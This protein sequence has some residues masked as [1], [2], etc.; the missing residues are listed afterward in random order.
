M[1]IKDVDVELSKD[2]HL[3]ADSATYFKSKATADVLRKERVHITFSPPHTQNKNAFAERSIGVITNMAKALLF[4]A[5]LPTSLWPEAWAHAILIR[6]Y[7]PRNANEESKSPYEMRNGKAPPDVASTYALFGQR[8]MVYIPRDQRSTKMDEKSRK[9]IIVGYD[10]ATKAAK[11]LTMSAR[12]Q[13][14]MRISDQYKLNPKLPKKMLDVEK[15]KVLPH[16]EDEF[17]YNEFNSKILPRD[18]NKELELDDE[19]VKTEDGVSVIIEQYVPV[20]S[21]GESVVW[22]ESE[23]TESAQSSAA[24]ASNPS[25]G[26]AHQINAIQEESEAQAKIFT[27]AVM[28][29]INMIN[30]VARQAYSLGTAIKMWP[31]HAE[32]L[33]RAAENEIQGLIEKS[34]IPVPETEINKDDEI[35]KLM[36]IYSLKYDAGLFDKAKCRCCYRGQDEIQGLHYVEK[37]TDMPRLSTI[38]IFL[39]LAPYKDEVCAK[40]DISQAFLRAELEP[41]PANERRFVQFPPD[42]SP[43]NKQGNI[44]TYRAKTGIYGMHS[45]GRQWQEM[46]FAWLKRIGMIQNETDPALFQTYNLRIVVWTD[47]I[48]IRGAPSSVTWIKEQLQREFGDVRWKALDYVLGMDIER[49]MN[50]WLGIH[51]KSYIDKMID[52]EDLGQAKPKAVPIPPSTRITKEQRA[53]SVDLPLRTKYQSVLGQL[54]YLATWTRPDLAYPTSSL[55][56]VASSPKQYHL[57]IARRVMTYCKRDPALGL[58]WKPPENP[59]MKNQI[60]IYTDA[61]WAQEEGYKSQSGFVAMMNGAPIHWQS[62]KQEFPALSSTESEIMAGSVALRHVLYLKRLLESMGEPQGVVTM[63]F[64]AANAIRFCTKEKVTKRNHHIGTRYMRIRHHVGKDV[65][66]EFVATN[67]MCADILTKNAQEHQ[68]RT[69]VATIMTHLGTP[70]AVMASGGTQQ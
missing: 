39:G 57:K 26:H 54:L 4:A 66:L 17:Y 44:Q 46:L 53:E 69:L 38:R 40:A 6:D 7:L 31:D 10:V 62:S 61:S 33:R 50:G 56:S 19:S 3:R 34:L 15:T 63:Y 25:E 51:S 21:N 67:A 37:A 58:K 1:N 49:D 45:A 47:D 22:D 13:T 48:I 23:S 2:L 9:G 27:P 70:G 59:K 20:S 11:I 65:E 36:S 18:V 68:F 14:V 41:I 64:D 42:I 12:G 29:L 16:E 30:K 52:K 5:E 43:R 35:S 8:C 60:Y 55:A 32:D 28:G 24:S